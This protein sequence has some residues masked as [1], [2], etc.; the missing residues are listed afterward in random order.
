VWKLISTRL[1]A[2][3]PKIRWEHNINEDLR[4]IKINNWKKCIQGQD[5]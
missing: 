3:R 2:G 5:M 1:A 4:I